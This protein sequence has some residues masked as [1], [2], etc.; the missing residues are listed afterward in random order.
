MMN[1][2]LG[3]ESLNT[4]NSVVYRNSETNSNLFN[5]CDN[6]L[7]EMMVSIENMFDAAKNAV[8]VRKALKQYGKTQSIVALIGQEGLAAAQTFSMEGFWQSAKN[9]LIKIWTKIK[10]W[11]NRFWSIFFSNEKAMKDLSVAKGKLNRPVEY[12]GLKLE[13]MDIQVKALERLLEDIK[14]KIETSSLNAG[15]YAAVTTSNAQTGQFSENNPQKNYGADIEVPKELEWTNDTSNDNGARRGRTV[16]F[17]Y[18]HVKLTD[19]ADVK[20]RAALLYKILSTLRKL[21][22]KIDKTSD[23]ALKA[24]EKIKDVNNSQ[25]TI[26]TSKAAAKYMRNI[27]QQYYREAN[28]EASKL[29]AHASIG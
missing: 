5:A 13:G 25:A 12:D 1:L 29:K 18:V 9:F 8:A 16:G 6:V 11:W 27:I 21:Q 19:V 10:E 2:N 24:A 26:E 7:G 28:T 23:R 20:K 22:D 3:L 17:S 15:T 4:T 14:K